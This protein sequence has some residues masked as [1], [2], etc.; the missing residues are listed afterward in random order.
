MTNPTDKRIFA[1]ASALYHSDSYSIKK[2]AS[3]TRIDL[4]F[5]SKMNNIITMTRTLETTDYKVLIICNYASARCTVVCASMCTTGGAKLLT[6]ANQVA[7]EDFV[8]SAMLIFSS[9]IMAYLI[10]YTLLSMWSNS[11]QFF[12]YRINKFKSGY[13]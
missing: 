2:L 10:V 13:I 4:W 12:F 6:F 11:N 3:L 7:N 9:Q 8:V 5:L 1:V